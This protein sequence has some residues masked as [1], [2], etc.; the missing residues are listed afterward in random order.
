VDGRCFIIAVVGSGLLA[1]APG[2][3]RGDG[4]AVRYSELHLDRIVT[5]FTSPT[6]LRTGPIDISILLQDADT[7]MALTN[8]PI[9]VHAELLDARGVRQ[10]ALDARAT[11]NAATNKLL[12]AAELN[13]PKPGRCRI[14]VSV[15]G[16]SSGPIGFD[17]DVEEGLPPWVETSIWMGWPLVAIAL[18]AIHQSLVCRKR[19]LSIPR[20]RIFDSRV[21]RGMPSFTAAPA[22]PETRPRH[23]D[24][25][26]SIN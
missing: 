9:D 24:R 20:V 17:V 8:V 15:K 18:F 13:L 3:A 21:D 10:M 25:A 6:P 11:S 1:Y 7:G 19:C 2:I 26:D 16:L 12:C 14:E 23:S 22:V 5:I 4:G